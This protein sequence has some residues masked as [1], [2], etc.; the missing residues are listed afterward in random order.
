MKMIFLLLFLF[1]LSVITANAVGIGVAPAELNF[2]IEK[3]KSQQKELTIYNLGDKETEFEVRSNADFM[4]FYHNGIIAAFGNEKIIVEA[5][6]KNL[7]EGNYAENIYITS[8]NGASGVHFNLG[9]AVKANVEVFKVDKTNLLTGII[10]FVA[11]LV[12]GLLFY[13]TMTK[14][15]RILAIVR[16][17]YW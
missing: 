3:G 8:S 4:E 6:A 7:K 9:T 2:K 14:A 13:L 10:T 11:V 12:V 16:K 1:L 17:N 5:I 15:N